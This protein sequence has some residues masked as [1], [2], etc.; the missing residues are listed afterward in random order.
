M[1][2]TTLPFKQLTQNIDILQF[3]LSHTY[4]YKPIENRIEIHKHF[5]SGWEI[6][7][8]YWYLFQAEKWMLNT[9]ITEVDAD[10]LGTSFMSICAFNNSS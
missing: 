1:L 5:F 4:E 2:N 3:R 6:D 7:A 8:E 10:G 9:F